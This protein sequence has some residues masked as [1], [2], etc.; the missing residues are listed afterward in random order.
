[1]YIACRAQLS[2]IRRTCRL[3]SKEGASV[4]VRTFWWPWIVEPVEPVLQSALASLSYT[5]NLFRIP[6]LWP[7][8]SHLRR[9]VP[10]QPMRVKFISTRCVNGRVGG[11]TLTI[12]QSKRCWIIC[13]A[14]QLSQ[15]VTCRSYVIK[16]G[17]LF[18]I[19]YTSKPLVHYR[20]MSTVIILSCGHGRD[21]LLDMIR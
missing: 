11:Y 2:P 8:Y 14:Y 15:P 13:S 9:A 20:L 16:L 5:R 1:M 19:K 17:T 12:N 10:I 21:K 4:M 18:E 3:F 6:C 7:L